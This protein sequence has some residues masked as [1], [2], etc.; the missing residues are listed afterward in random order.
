[1]FPSVNRRS[2]AWK[3]SIGRNHFL[4]NTSKKTS[5]IQR[6]YGGILF[7]LSGMKDLSLITTF[8]KKNQRMNDNF[9][10][11]MSMFIAILGVTFCNKTPAWTHSYTL[12]AAISQRKTSVKC[13]SILCKTNQFNNWKC[14]YNKYCYVFSA[15]KESIS[16]VFMLSFLV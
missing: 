11:I 12:A 2:F 6:M 10:H 16:A 13:L 8:S 7:K 9:V 1:M 5:N 14:S 15:V 4:K 3:P